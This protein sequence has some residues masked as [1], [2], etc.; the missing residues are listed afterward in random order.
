MNVFA[1][2]SK[3][4]TDKAHRP[5]ALGLRSVTAGYMRNTVILN[6]LILIRRRNL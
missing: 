2:Q 1:G 6:S 5:K 4:V 3:H